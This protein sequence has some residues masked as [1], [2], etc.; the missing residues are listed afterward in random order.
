MGDKDSSLAHIPEDRYHTGCAKDAN[1]AEVAIMG[2]H[3]KPEYSRKGILKI[4]K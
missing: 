2:H 1:L 3:N 4:R